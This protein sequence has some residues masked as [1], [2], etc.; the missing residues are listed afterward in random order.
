[1]LFDRRRREHSNGQA[2]AVRPLHSK[3][4]ARPPSSDW[5]A[6]ES[7]DAAERREVQRRRRRRGR[8][9]NLHVGVK[10]LEDLFLYQCRWI[11]VVVREQLHEALMEQW[12]D[13]EHHVVDRSAIF[14]LLVPVKDDAVSSFVR[15]GSARTRSAARACRRREERCATCRS[16]RWTG[17][18]EF[19]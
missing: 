6:L 3:Y 9:T 4:P 8:T 14:E 7:S 12:Q 15:V 16:C 19:D 17:R 2:N 13:D 18:C 5:T 1:M 10:Y 11:G